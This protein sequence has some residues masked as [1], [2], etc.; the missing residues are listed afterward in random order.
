MKVKTLIFLSVLSI[1][2]AC[3]EPSKPAP[4]S[5]GTKT[6]LEKTKTLLEQTD[7]QPIKRE[8][9]N[10]TNS[11]ADKVLAYFNALETGDGRF[12]RLNVSKKGHVQHHFKYINGMSG[13]KQ[14]IKEFTNDFPKIDVYRLAE[15]NDY[16][17][18][19]SVFENSSKRE[20]G[21]DVFRF[22]DGL[23]TE[24]YFGRE[25]IKEQPGFENISFN[26][27]TLT[28]GDSDD[29]LRLKVAA[30]FVRFSRIEDDQ[31]KNSKMISTTYTEHNPYLQKSK[32]P[33]DNYY[34]DL[35]A[36]GIDMNYDKLINAIGGQ[37]FVVVISSGTKNGEPVQ[38]FDLFRF[39]GQKI[40]EH[41]D[42]IQLLSINN[43]IS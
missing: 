5:E 10:L 16:V 1:T 36:A 15:Y 11:N 2:Y 40:T 13:Y 43:P 33:V 18:A 32:N 34:Q 29:N 6:E 26:G 42:V 38:I 3:N 12:F 9:D 20:T 41:W 17:I 8:K 7:G 22:K 23:I 31:S 35:K 21:I 4:L 28:K 14:M 37:N 25:E 30:N 24:H 39:N 19:H 27:T